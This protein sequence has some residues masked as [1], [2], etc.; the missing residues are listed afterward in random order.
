MPMH[1]T[2]AVYL[3]NFHH[4]KYKFDILDLLLLLLLLFFFS[5][6][7]N[8]I[9][10]EN[11]FWFWDFM[12]LDRDFISIGIYPNAFCV[13]LVVYFAIFLDLATPRDS[14][15]ISDLTLLTNVYNQNLQFLT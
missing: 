9:S 13:F 12:C 8:D 6:I 11:P 3:V 1:I 15:K 14:R 5:K 2:C 10:L 4:F 7:L